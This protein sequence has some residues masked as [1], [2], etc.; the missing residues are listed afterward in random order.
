MYII[1]KLL[2][3]FEELFYDHEFQKKHMCCDLNNL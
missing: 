1:S 3:I 2:G